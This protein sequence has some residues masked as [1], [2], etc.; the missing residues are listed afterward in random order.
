[1]LQEGAG[2]VVDGGAQGRIGEKCREEQSWQE[3][4]V[5]DEGKTEQEGGKPVCR[6]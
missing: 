3:G 2:L 1:M 6:V 4:Q 5:V